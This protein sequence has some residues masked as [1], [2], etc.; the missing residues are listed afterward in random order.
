MNNMTKF[1]AFLS[2]FIIAVLFTGAVSAAN[3]AVISQS[4]IQMTASNMS[5]NNTI[6]AEKING[7]SYSKNLD[8]NMPKMNT[9]GIVM[10]ST[11]YN[12]G[13][14]ALATVL[15][16]I[17]VNATQKDLAKL[18]KTGKNGTTMYGLQQ[19]AQSKGLT[20][21]GLHLLPNELKSTNIVFLI[22]AKEGTYN[23][24]TKITKNTIYLADPNLG[25]IC[26]TIKD[27]ASIYSGYALFVTKDKNNPHLS[28]GTALTTKKMKSITGTGVPNGYK[29]IYAPAKSKTVPW[30]IHFN[31][32]T[33]HVPGHWVN[34]AKGRYY[35]TAFT[36]SYHNGV[37]SS[38]AHYTYVPKSKPFLSAADK[39]AI[40]NGVRELGEEVAFHV[41]SDPEIIPIIIFLIFA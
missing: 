23:V 7:S 29:S 28:N 32:F 4:G 5:P 40:A 38:T 13:P 12:C 31:N 20:A 11:D 8:K 27:F 30:Y 26:M 9:T 10:A 25:N 33:L 24:V 22:I 39:K 21:K 41:A 36:I 2:I 6:T 15:N 35:I 34:T 17:G 3:P 16:K 14:A 18:A 19:A 1:L 37:I